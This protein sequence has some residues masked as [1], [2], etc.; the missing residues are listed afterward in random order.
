ME[1]QI[2]KD[3][4]YVLQSE[5]GKWIEHDLVQEKHVRIVR[6]NTGHEYRRGHQIK[7]EEAASAGISQ[8]N[9]QHT[10][11]A[12]KRLGTEQGARLETT[13]THRDWT[14]DK[15]AVKAFANTFLLLVN[16]KF[17]MKGLSNGEED[18][19]TLTSAI[20]GQPLDARQLDARLIGDEKVK[21]YGARYYI[22]SENVV[23][24][25]EKDVGMA[26]ISASSQKVSDKI[27][28]LRLRRTSTDS[29]EVQKNGSKEE[30][31]KEFAVIEPHLSRG[32]KR[33]IPNLNTS[34]L[35]GTSKKVLANIL[36]GLRKQLFQRKPELLENLKESV[37]V[38]VGDSSTSYERRTRILEHEYYAQRLCPPRSEL[39]FNQRTEFA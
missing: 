28:R 23:E 31:Y 1:N 9:K 27:D 21:M 7:V 39:M 36:V 16:G 4:L 38:E 10:K 6:E 34:Q 20:D 14:Q 30:L 26:K 15:R 17:F 37:R 29:A 5:Q 13:K 32:Q 12:I 19:T 33:K 25:K 2:V 8:A 3:R 22:D 18:D 24:R 11:H 35:N